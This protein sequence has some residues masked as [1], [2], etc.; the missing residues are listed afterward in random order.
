MPGLTAEGIEIK[1]LDT[2]KTELESDLKT[3]LGDPDFN[4]EADSVAGQLIGVFAAKLLE[5]WELLEDIYHA[6]YPDTAVGQ[7]L[8]YLSTLTGTIKRPSTKATVPVSIVSTGNPTLPEGSAV[9]VDGDP[10]SRFEL[11]ADQ[12]ITISP[13]VVTFTAS[14]AGSATKAFAVDTAVIETPVSGWDSASFSADYTPGEDVEKDSALR[15]RRETE[16]ARPG[17]STV[18]AIRADM[19]GVTGVTF[20]AVF[21]N[22]GDKTDANG[23]PPKSVEVLVMGTYNTADVG[24]Q[25][26]D[27]K[28][29]GTRTFGTNAA[30][31][32]D[33][34]GNTHQVF[35]SVPTEVRV[36]I[37]VTLTTDSDY[38]GDTAVQQ[39]I[40]DWG[41][42][43]V[44][45]QS[46]Y[47]SDVI[48]VV[49]A[50][51]GVV[52]VDVSATFV[53]DSDPP[54]GSTSWIAGTREIG[55]IETSDVDVTS[56]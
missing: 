8:A 7:A 1:D 45:G 51:A 25:I 3:A 12:T 38:V 14:V 39:A 11:L 33:D 16:L 50:L 35:Y 15:T 9:Y 31:A 43:V 2:L 44:L 42:T 52:S 22:T 21:E 49:S 18:P 6:A 53:S 20:A 19:T 27:S 28:P 30:T 26:W 34:A 56:S 36:H 32:V 29:A 54:T 13:E 48:A 4:V 47:A 5:I 37:A 24:Q 41:N 40:S 46:V 17:T 55:T 23:V 10:E